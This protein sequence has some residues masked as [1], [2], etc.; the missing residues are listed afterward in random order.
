[1]KAFAIR[2]DVHVLIPA[3]AGVGAVAWVGITWLRGLVALLS[4][5]VGST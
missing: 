1:M 4:D 5:H 2:N 3:Q